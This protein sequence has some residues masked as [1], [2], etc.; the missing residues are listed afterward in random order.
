MSGRATLPEWSLWEPGGAAPLVLT[1]EHLCTKTPE[2][3]DGDGAAEG[4]PAYGHSSNWLTVRGFRPVG[5]L[6]GPGI[7][8]GLPPGVAVC[9]G[10]SPGHIAAVM[11]LH[12]G[13]DNSLRVR[14]STSGAA[15][16][17][18]R[19]PECSGCRVTGASPRPRPLNRRRRVGAPLPGVFSRW[20]SSPLPPSAKPQPPCREGSTDV[21]SMARREGYRPS[22][23]IPQPLFLLQGG[24]NDQAIHYTNYHNQG[25]QPQPLEWPRQ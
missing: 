15:A 18:S 24:Q 23:A 17:A 3:L 2:I 4:A 22:L 1:M 12:Q 7:V 6:D 19:W 8:T 16:S 14:Y 10:R 5:D 13:L 9:R 21:Q 25:L 11:G 20:L